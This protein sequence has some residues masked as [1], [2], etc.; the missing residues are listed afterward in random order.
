M[1]SYP[2]EPVAEARRLF[3][4]PA[5]LM[6]VTAVA[7][8]FIFTTID[9]YSLQ[10]WQIVA[11]LALAALVLGLLIGPMSGITVRG[12]PSPL[13]IEADRL[14]LHVRGSPPLPYPAEVK[15]DRISAVLLGGI[16]PPKVTWMALPGEKRQGPYAAM[17]LT[18]EN[19]ERVRSAWETWKFKGRTLPGASLA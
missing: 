10:S 1:T 16:A 11:I 2:N 17:V 14:L 18:R 6:A 8:V 19:A 13:D 3:L 9:G 5:I 15:F 4:V 12:V 7:L